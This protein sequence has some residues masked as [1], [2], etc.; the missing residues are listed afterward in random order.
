ME[1]D[2][3]SVFVGDEEVAVL[4][5]SLVCCKINRQ[6]QCQSPRW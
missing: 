2:A 1:V 3:R 5:E 6:L 4:R